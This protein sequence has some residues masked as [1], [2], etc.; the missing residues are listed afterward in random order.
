MVSLARIRRLEELAD[1]R[2]ETAL[3]RPDWLDAATLVETRPDM[4]IYEWPNDDVEGGIT[5]AMVWTAPNGTPTHA[6]VLHGIHA[7]D[8]V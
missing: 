8:L 6:T 7:N 5:S 3:P 4:R 1:Q 2:T